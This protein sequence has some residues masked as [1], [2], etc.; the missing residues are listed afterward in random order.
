LYIIHVHAL[1][2]ATA[3]IGADSLS[4]IAKALEQAGKQEDLAFIHAHNA[5]FIMDLEALLRNI[6]IFLSEEAG[7]NQKN[8]LDKESLKNELFRLKAALNNFDFTEINNAADVLQEF[9]QSAD[10]GDAVSKI[11]QNKLIGE[12]DDAISLID[13]LTQRLN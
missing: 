4:D 2:S 13:T 7:K 6:N 1:K 5:A 3:I 9:T 10:V 11:L 8:S 12:Y